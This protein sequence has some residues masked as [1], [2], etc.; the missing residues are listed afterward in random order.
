[1][2]PSCKIDVD[3]IMSLI[4]LICLLWSISIN[5]FF[6]AIV[7]CFSVGFCLKVL[8]DTVTMLTECRMICPISVQSYLSLNLRGGRQTGFGKPSAEGVSEKEA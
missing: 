8:Y 2:G 3:S 7:E 4:F 6:Y 1:M 5:C